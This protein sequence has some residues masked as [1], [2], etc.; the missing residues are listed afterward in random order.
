MLGI[1]IITINPIFLTQKMVPIVFFIELHSQKATTTVLMKVLIG[2]H[3]QVGD[4]LLVF[5]KTV[6]T[7]YTV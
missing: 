1:L 5:T 6:A 4:L 7:Y 3:G 2:L